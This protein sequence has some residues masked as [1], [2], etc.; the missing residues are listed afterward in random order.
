MSPK[1]K[2]KFNVEM[3]VPNTSCY[4]L[5]FYVISYYSYCV[6]FKSKLFFYRIVSHFVG[7]QASRPLSILKYLKSGD[8]VQ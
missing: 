7:P 1:F 8:M 4:S 5:V 6:A 2:V 3:T